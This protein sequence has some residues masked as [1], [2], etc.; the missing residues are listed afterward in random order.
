MAVIA[1][2]TGSAL[3][4][5][6]AADA[7]PGIP[8]DPAPTGQDPAQPGTQTRSV[9]PQSPPGAAQSQAVAVPAT[10]VAGPQDLLSVLFGLGTGSA[11][12]AVGSAAVGSAGLGAV[13]GGT[14]SAA[15]GSGSAITG[16]AGAGLG[17]AVAGTGSAGAATGSAVLGTGSAAVGSA[18][19]G[20]GSVL[21]LGSAAVGSAGLGTGSALL[22]LLLGTGSAAT[23]SAAVGSAAVGSAG[24]AVLLSSLDLFIVN[25]ALPR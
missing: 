12:A 21:S 1:A 24:L 22:G 8:L 6:A 2:V 16:S 11:G 20:A 14:G 5:P 10:P 15:L 17:S 25:V 13:L 23:G 19:L 18:G 9:V 3:L 7:Q 4:G